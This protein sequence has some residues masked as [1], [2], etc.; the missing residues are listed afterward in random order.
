MSTMQRMTLIGVNEYTDGE[1]WSK[2]TLPEPLNNDDTLQ[3]IINLIMLEHGEKCVLYSSPDFMTDAIGLWCFKWHDDIKRMFDA[4]YSEYNPIHNYDRHEEYTDTESID[5]ESITNAGHEAT[6][7]PDYNVSQTTNGTNEHTVSADNSS[8]YQPDYLDTT[9]AGTTNT[10]GKTQDLS[11]T[12]QSETTDQ[13]TRNF[14]HDAHLYGNIG[15]TTS[16]QMIEAEAKL[17]I[18]HNIADIIGRLFA[19]ELLINIY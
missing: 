1:V 10:S 11:E 17:R 13:T 6:D 15:V 2:F 14:S 18:T 9:N 3:T 12:S 5:Y 16:Q 4:I 19:N 7:R 8:S